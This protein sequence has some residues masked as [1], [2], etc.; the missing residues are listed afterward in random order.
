MTATGYR[1]SV[2]GIYEGKCVNGGV[3]EAS[4]GGSEV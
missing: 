1:K 3:R 4:S 2:W